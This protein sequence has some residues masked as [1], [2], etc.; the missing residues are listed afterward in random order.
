MVFL[1]NRKAKREEMP[2]IKNK[3]YRQFIDYGQMDLVEKPLFVQWLKGI[4]KHK[5]PRR[6][7]LKQAEALFICVYYTGRRPDEIANLK[8][9][10]VEKVHEGKKYYIKISYLTLKG[11]VRNTIWLPFNV[12]TKK[13]YEYMKNRPPEMFCFWAFRSPTKNT[14][15][16]ASRKD[17]L[18]K[19][20]GKLHHEK[21]VEN[22]SKVYTRLG[23]KI[24][25]Y[26]VLWTGRNA[27]FFRHNRFSLMYANGA[28]DEQV[29]LFKGAK[30]PKS[31]NAYK[32]MSKKLAVSITKLF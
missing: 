25:Y 11:G 20:D 24:N 1:G 2:R 14:V 9:E 15:K 27:Y 21:Y 6:C 23:N 5:L 31:V 22:K 19:E 3:Y 32:H 10:D 7:T 28:S 8:G 12:Y 29:Q 16:W 13:M 17:I 30:D 18:V 4:K 26:C